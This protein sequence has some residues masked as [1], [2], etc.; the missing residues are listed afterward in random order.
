[1]CRWIL[2]ALLDFARLLGG[3]GA[4]MGCDSFAGGASAGAVAAFGT[5]ALGHEGVLAGG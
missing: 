1:M 3:V 2:G 5:A 4:S